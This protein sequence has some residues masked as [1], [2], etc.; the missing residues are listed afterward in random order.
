MNALKSLLD[1]GQS[2]WLDFVRR[3]MLRQGGLT[4][5]IETDGL[6]GVTSNPAIFQ[7]AIAAGDDYDDAVRTIVERDNPDAGRLF[8]ALAIED[9][10]EAADQLRGVYDETEG[11]D[12]FV[13]LEVSPYLANDTESTVEEGLRL[14]RSVDRPNLMV[15]VPATPAGLPAIRRLTASGINVNVTLL[16]AQDVYGQ[17]V[18]AFMSGL[19]DLVGE[20]RDPSK[21]ASVASFFVSRIDAAVEE[22]I[23][24]RMAE[25]SSD[26]RARLEGLKGKVAIA[27][28]KLAY[29]IYRRLHQSERWAKLADAGAQPQRLLWASTGTKNKAFS[30]VLYVE[31][32]VGTDTVNTMPPA[33]MDAFRDH[34]RAGLTLEGDLDEAKATLDGLEAVGID[35]DAIT[36]DLVAQGVTLF[37]DAADE[38]YAAVEYKRQAVLADAI[39]RQSEALAPELDKAVQAILGE[40]RASGG[41]RR[42]W[43]RDASLWTG[44]DEAKWLGWLDVVDA[45]NAGMA[46]LEA[47][48]AEVKQRGFTDLVLIGMGGSSLGPEVLAET[49]GRQPGFPEV[50]VIDSTDPGQ[51]AATLAAIAVPTTL[52]I[53]ASK[54]GGTLEPNILKDFFLD[55]ATQAL[56]DD[57]GRHFV[58]ITD[59]GSNMETVAKAAGFWRVFYGVPSIGGR[60]SVLSNFGLVPAAAMG[61]DVRRFVESTALMVRACGPTVP[62]AANPGV[63]LGAVWGAAW[64][65]GRDKLTVVAGDGVRDLGAWLEQLVAESTGKQGFAII[66]VDGEALAAPEAYGHDRLFLHL[67]RKDRPA[68]PELDA[69]LDALRQAGHPVVSIAL[70]EPYQLG[71]EFFRLEMATAVA[72]SVMGINPFDQPD[73]EASKV[74]TRKLTDAFEK[75]GALPAEEPVLEADGIRV[76]ADA[77][78]ADALKAARASDLAGAIASL[79]DRVKPSDY[80]AF[81]AYVPRN[82][83]NDA[84]LQAMRLAARDRLKV[85]TCVGFGPR[86]LHSTGQAY[87]GG[88]NTGVFLQITADPEADL[89]V[90]GKSYSFGVV[91]AAQAQGDLAVLRERGRRALRFHLTGGIEAGLASLQA[92]IARAIE[93]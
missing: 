10:Q 87:K 50:T 31:E 65:E 41:I 74:E 55:Q 80:V 1:Y 64:Q 89:P 42:L 58:A 49:F 44:Q 9:I 84:P 3:N 86:F 40:W 53:V 4:K 38:L 51:V 54:S 72:G 2:P 22:Q 6:R 56:G 30:D 43:Q 66:P 16:F 67:S 17:V 33:T 39:D 45:A 68:E 63:K 60:Y 69:K 78:N 52:F 47:F 90:P 14:W 77:A 34:G 35:L 18:D 20:G 83:A 37:A 19:E 32:L 21:V 36:R 91:Q 82:A 88:P 81:L 13:S 24:A 48:A 57:A 62:P 71:Q 93:G 70:A 46:D 28:A 85:A 59:P 15:K 23:D 25:A 7:K 79:I 29:Q 26:E 75:S 76:F 61:I 27:N 8:E 5:L 73:V 11:R 12:G 92:A